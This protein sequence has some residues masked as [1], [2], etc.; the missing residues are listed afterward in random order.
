MSRTENTKTK[1][2]LVTPVTTASLRVAALCD[3]KV[4][5]GRLCLSGQYLSHFSFKKCY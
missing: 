5:A 2:S 4:H 3:G 1:V